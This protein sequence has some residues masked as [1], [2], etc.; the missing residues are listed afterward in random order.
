MDQTVRF[1]IDKELKDVNTSGDLVFSQ[2]SVKT[3]EITKPLSDLRISLSHDVQADL[4]SGKAD[5]K[6]VR[7]SF[8]KVFLNLNGTVSNFNAVRISICRSIPIP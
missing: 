7:L 4:I 5:L 3:K 6:M 8:Q 1:S 2:V